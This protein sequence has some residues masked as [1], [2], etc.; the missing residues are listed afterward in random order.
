MFAKKKM[1]RLGPELMTICGKPAFGGC[2]DAL[3]SCVL[4][5]SVRA[6]CAGH[7]VDVSRGCARAQS[8]HV[9]QPLWPAT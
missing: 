9:R 8:L 7:A 4:Q 1:K 6:R 3:G 2:G 5:V